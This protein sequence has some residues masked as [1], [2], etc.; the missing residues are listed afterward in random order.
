LERWPDEKR[1]HQALLSLPNLYK[2]MV[3]KGL[4][5]DQ[6]ANP[7]IRA[8]LDQFIRKYPNSPAAE[9]AR[10]QVRYYGA[11]MEGSTHEE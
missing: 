4:L 10:Q 3:L 11:I 6:Q 5:T 1:N 8:A 2:E 9:M 7:L